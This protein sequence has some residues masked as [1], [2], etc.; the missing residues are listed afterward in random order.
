MAFTYAPDNIPNGGRDR[1]RF[2]V[3][4]T[5]STDVRLQDEEISGALAATNDD[6]QRAAGVC[7]RAIANKLRRQVEKAGAIDLGTQ[8]RIDG[9]LAMADRLDGGGSLQVPGVSGQGLSAGGMAGAEGNYFSKGMQ[10]NLAGQGDGYPF[11]GR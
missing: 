8:N 6:W 5:D 10:N 1:V 2:E 3:G 11:G 4:D 7:A 9:Y